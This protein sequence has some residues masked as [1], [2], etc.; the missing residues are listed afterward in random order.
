MNINLKK[1][2]VMILQKHNSKLQRLNFFLGDKRIDITIEYTYLGLK[3]TP[4]TKFAVGTQQL[5]EKAMHAVFKIRKH[6]DFHKLT[7]KL[8]MK[9][10]DGIVSPILLYNSEVWGGVYANNDFIKWDKTSTEKTHLKFCKIYLGVNRKASNIASR[11]ELG[12]FPLLLPHIEK[13]IYIK[14]ISQLS[15]SSI[16]K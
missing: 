3:L 11:G 9:I 12:K 10:F 15:D 2:K 5:S 16:A 4:N 8:A 1:T 7:P 6:L 13:T 14:H